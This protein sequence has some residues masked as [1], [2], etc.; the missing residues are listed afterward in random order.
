MQIDSLVS[1]LWRLVTRIQTRASSD[2]RQVK[3]AEPVT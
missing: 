1:L 2:H 3:K